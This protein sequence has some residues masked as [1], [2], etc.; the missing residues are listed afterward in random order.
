VS[1]NER[2]GRAVVVTTCG[3]QV[4]DLGD[5]LGLLAAEGKKLTLKSVG[6]GDVSVADVDQDR[7]DLAAQRGR[8]SRASASRL[9]A[10]PVGSLPAT[11]S[12]FSVTADP[13]ERIGESL[14]V[15]GQALTAEGLR[16]GDPGTPPG[17]ALARRDNIRNCAARVRLPRSDLRSTGRREDQRLGRGVEGARVELVE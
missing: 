10:R 5:Q 6:L 8:R 11:P 16:A 1:W 13:A 14:W 17:H 4:S 15:H 3:F 7:G 9:T 2:T 12:R